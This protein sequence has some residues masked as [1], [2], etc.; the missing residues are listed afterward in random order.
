MM[1]RM[2]VFAAMVVI[3]NLNLNLLRV[4]HYGLILYEIDAVNSKT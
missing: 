1:R 3:F 4:T 2:V